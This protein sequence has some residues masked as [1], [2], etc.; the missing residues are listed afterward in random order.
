MP[1]HPSPNEITITFPDGG[2]R[3]Y[4]KGITV[5][6]VA[7]SISEGL[8]RATLDAQFN[9]QHVDFDTKLE[10]DGT[11]KLFTFKDQEG[12]NALRHSCAHLL[13]AS[14][15]ELYPSAE[16]AIG[17]PIEDGFYQDF[18]LPQ[19]ISEADFPKIE[20]KMRDLAKTWIVMKGKEVT[21]QEALSQFKKNKYKTELAKEFGKEGKKI[22]FQIAGSFIDLCKGG[23]V[24]NPG[25][26]LQYFKLSSVA[27]AY[28]RGDQKNKMLT[29]IY[30]T[31]FPSKKE[32]DEH[33]W[34]QEEAKK[35][36]HRKLGK[37]LDLFTFHELSPGSAMFYPKGAYIYNKLQQF[38][39]EEYHK[40]S[41]QEVITPQL[42][43]KSLWE[44]SGHWEH[45]KDNM[46]LTQVE[47]QD[48]SLKPMNCPSHLLIYKRK[49]HSY[50]DLPIRMADFCCLHRNELSGVLGGLLRVRKFS[51]DDAHLFMTEEQLEDELLAIIDFAEFI[52]KKVFNFDYH[53]ELSTKP[54][55][56]MG[57][58]ELWQKAEA[59]LQN[60]LKK[61]NLPFKINP[62][63]GAFYGP[64]ID[65][66]IKDA[67]GRSWQ[68]ATIQLDFN[69][70]Q[71]F[72]ANYEGKDGKKHQVIM[73]HRAL[74]G[75]L[76]RFIGVLT[77]HFT[78]RFPLWLSPTQVIILTVADRHIA[79]AETIRKQYHDAGLQVEVDDRP[80]SVPKKVRDAQLHQWNYILV[81]GDKEIQDNTVTV[82]TRKN[83]I[84]GM[85]KGDVFLNELLAEIEKKE[86]K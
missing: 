78:G 16:N 9:S 69:Q 53:I 58:P 31:A 77:E 81:V 17:P 32:L 50:R 29:R 37:E 19:P 71:R 26:N 27:G 18:E 82:R 49:L 76:E 47:G 20:Q 30:G 22:T 10:Q 41:Y 67:I 1:R 54:E 43:H 21:L 48:F 5:E 70:P 8:A 84:L 23:H 3:K 24:F 44:T 79:F 55:K 4:P 59:S 28:W 75:S 56:A 33:F 38:I 73:V 61:K 35:R 65:F 36:D 15:L 2:I 14:V 42:F 45:Y 86:I 40:R 46:F 64:K 57:A 85:K 74:L 34:R 7:K 62:G 66:H 83:E 63:D 12:K 6:E 25:K 52:Y 39:R 60:A 11:F 72:D 68:C 80:E 51:Q 13:A